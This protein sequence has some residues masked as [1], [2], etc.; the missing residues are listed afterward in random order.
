[1]LCFLEGIFHEGQY[2]HY[3]EG[4]D[5]LDKCKNVTPKSKSKEIVTLVMDLK[6]SFGYSFETGSCYKGA[7][8]IDIKCHNVPIDYVTNVFGWKS[9]FKFIYHCL[10]N[11]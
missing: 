8:I 5:E 2:L 3:I 4:D 9:L 1:M 10:I 11:Q 7:V 6:S